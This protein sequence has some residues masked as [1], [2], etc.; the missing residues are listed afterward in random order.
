MILRLAFLLAI[1]SLAACAAPAEEDPGG[2]PSGESADDLVGRTLNVHPGAERRIGLGLHTVRPTL[3]EKGNVID[4]FTDDL[5]IAGV[6]PE[7]VLSIALQ[8]PPGTFESEFYGFQV[9]Y[10]TAGSTTWQPFVPVIGNSSWQWRSVIASEANGTWRLLGFAQR[11]ADTLGGVAPS[12]EWIQVPEQMVQL[13]PAIELRVHVLPL[14]NFWDWDETGYEA[15][16]E[17]SKVKSN[18]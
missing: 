15:I 4:V 9:A 1:L 7:G 6:P 13:G 12:L 2:E 14:W 10:R 3:K 16:L 11:Y 18:P 5:V 8:E 17:V